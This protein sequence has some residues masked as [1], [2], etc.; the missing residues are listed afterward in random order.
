MVECHAYGK[1][2][3]EI[4]DYFN[5]HTYISQINWTAYVL[6]SMRN[7]KNG[8]KPFSDTPFKGALTIL[9]T[10]EI[11]SGGFGRG[12]FIRLSSVE[13]ETSKLNNEEEL[14]K[15]D[16]LIQALA[17]TFEN[18][19][20][21]KVDVQKANDSTEL[22]INNNSVLGVGSSRSGKKDTIDER[23]FDLCVEVN[24]PRQ[25]FIESETDEEETPEDEIRLKDKNHGLRGKD[26][27]LEAE[28]EGNH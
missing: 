27:V 11:A 16:L 8:W 28:H 1:C 24:A 26:E 6:D 17:A 19:F 20:K 4:L 22:G 23:I 18:I 13:G 7:C 5:D 3:L 21:E 14:K 25:R 12:K 10:L 9:T 15:M 2:K